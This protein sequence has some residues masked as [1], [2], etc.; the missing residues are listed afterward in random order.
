MIALLEEIQP[1]SR[2]VL[3]NGETRMA[4]VY[5]QSVKNVITMLSDKNVF[6]PMD[7][8]ITFE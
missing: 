6:D 2:T 8:L 7:I 3:A 5:E 4:Q 1:T